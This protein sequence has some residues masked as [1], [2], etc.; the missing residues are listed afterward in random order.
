MFIFEVLNN[1]VQ[2]F[3]LKFFHFVYRAPDYLQICV[4]IENVC[5]GSSSHPNIVAS[6]RFLRLE[7]DLGQVWQAHRKAKNK[8]EARKLPRRPSFSICFFSISDA[9][10]LQKVGQGVE[11]K[12]HQDGAQ[13]EPRRHAT[14][15]CLDLWKK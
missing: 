6:L 14:N 1:C 11:H 7:M 10:K 8:N 2:D 4:L 5:G 3:D 12:G 9:T 15:I 13:M